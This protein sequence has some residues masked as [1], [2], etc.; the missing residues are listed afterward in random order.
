ME[1]TRGSLLMV[2]AMAA[3]AIEDMLIKLTAGML[4]VGE[5]LA[6]LGIV[7]TVVFA[8]LTR[9]RGQSILSPAL[10]TPP[11][12]LRNLGEMCGTAAYTSAFV[13]ATLSA[14]A[15]ILQ[16][17]PLVVTMGAA[18]FLGETVMWRRWLA[19]ALGLL[20]VLLVTQP[21]MAGFTPASL[22]AVGAVLGLGLRD[23]AVRKIPPRVTSAQVAVWAFAAMIMAGT[24][25]MLV[26]RTPPLW[27]TSKE[28]GWLAGACVASISGYYA[29]VCAT[30][31]GDVSVVVLYRYIRLPFAMTL[32][33]LVFGEHPDTLTLTGAALIVVA[34]LYTMWREAHG[35]RR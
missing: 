18:L 26:M 35:S 1:N 20:G 28:V 10:L 24:L 33:I 21:G 27:P 12:M 25:M 22:F 30:R 13:F 19:I 15:A 17:L 8:T 4:P 9:I 6:S 32:G 2:A 16:A 31:T 3:F 7:G 34:G 29:L 14:A 23:T 11:V 5:V